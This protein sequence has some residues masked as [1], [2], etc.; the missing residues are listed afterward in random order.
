MTT[1]RLQLHP[2]TNLPDQTL[3]RLDDATFIPMALDN[4]HYLRFKSDILSGLAQLENADGVIMSAE[5]AK[6]F[7]ESLP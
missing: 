1:Y 7:I 3:Q 6:K 2:I 5:S 4:Q